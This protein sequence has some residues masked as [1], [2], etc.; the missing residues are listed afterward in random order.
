[1][2]V[3]PLLCAS[4]LHKIS[5]VN[6]PGEP[7]R[8][9]QTRCAV[10]CTASSWAGP[11]IKSTLAYLFYAVRK[12][13][14]CNCGVSSRRA[15]EATVGITNDITSAVQQRRQ[16]VRVQLS[17]AL[18]GPMRGCSQHICIDAAFPLVM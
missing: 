15:S 8:I 17:H 9:S 2:Y 16:T 5:L 3:L 7:P 14:P 1:M 18:S 13:S 6:V 10:T 11:N 12:P 4:C